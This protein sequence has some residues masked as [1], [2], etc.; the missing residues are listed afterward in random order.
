[1]Q[2]LK[3]FSIPIRGLKIGHHDYAYVIDNDFFGAIEHSP[4]Q[5]GQF[6]FKVSLEKKSDNL[7]FHLDFKGHLTLD[8]DRCTDTISFPL[9][10]DYEMIV[11]YDFEER[12]EE[13]VIYIHPE[14]SEFNCS[15]LVFDA[16]ML[17][18][19]MHKTCDSVENKECD[20]DVLDR[21]FS[22]PPENENENAFSKALKN[23]KL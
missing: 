13:E 19:P 3:Q 21:F 14:S 1:M 9:K 7:E 20:Q 22:K 23:L 15:K 8:C 16:I 5:G 10:G 18:L 6:D 2:V 4:F 11:K 12:E 17:S